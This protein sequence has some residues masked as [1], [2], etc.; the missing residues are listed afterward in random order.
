MK[1]FDL[2]CFNEKSPIT[3]YNRALHIYV[4]FFAVCT[5]ILIYMGGL[6]KTLNAGLSVPDWPLSWGGF[7]PPRWTE[8]E[9]VRAEHSHRLMATFVGLLSIGL[10]IWVWKKVKTS[11]WFKWLVT[12]SL[13]AVVSQGILGGITVLFYLPDA[14]SMSHA[15]LAQIFLL[16]NISIAVFASNKWV[17]PQQKIEARTSGLPVQ[18]IF[19]A[20]LS[21]IFIQLILGAWVRHTESGLAIPDFPLSNGQLIPQFT[22]IHIIAAYSHRVWAMVVSGMI[23]WSSISVFKNYS[24]VKPLFKTAIFLLILLCCQVTLGAF[25]IWTVRST[26]ITTLHVPVGALTLGTTYYLVLQSF[27]LISRPVTAFQTDL[28]TS[29]NPS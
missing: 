17:V 6:I 25:I 24:D 9:T 7:N 5:L 12:C 27:R 20:T 18:Y 13:I 4:I 19:S 14:I 21:T 10:N 28:K 8:I 15:T 26:I 23:I 1:L 11:K 16:I 3:E 29:V 22:D 2:K